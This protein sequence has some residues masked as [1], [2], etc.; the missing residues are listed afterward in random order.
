M[1]T[2]PNHPNFADLVDLNGFLRTRN[3]IGNFYL[4][5]I[6]NNLTPIVKL[7]QSQSLWCWNLCQSPSL[8]HSVWNW[9]HEITFCVKKSKART[10]PK[11]FMQYLSMSHKLHLKHSKCMLTPLWLEKLGALGLLLNYQVCPS[12]K[13][14]LQRKLAKFAYKMRLTQHHRIQQCPSPFPIVIKMN[15]QVNIHLMEKPIS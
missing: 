15:I 12:L 6:V 14:L 13:G 8:C 10:E 11:Q 2:K 4:E 9:I 7:A 1:K 3:V 5:V